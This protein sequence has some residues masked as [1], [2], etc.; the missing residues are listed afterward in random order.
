MQK[1][2]EWKAKYFSAEGKARVAERRS[3]LSPEFQEKANRD[4]EELYADVEASIG[5]D[6][7]GPKGQALAAR[8]KKLVDGFTGGDPEILKSL[9]AMM[10]DKANWPSEAQKGRFAKPQLQEFIRKA[11][12][13]KN[14]QEHNRGRRRNCPRGGIPTR[15]I[16]F[17]DQIS[18][19]VHRS[20][21][22]TTPSTPFASSVTTMEVI[23]RFSIRFNA[24]L[25]SRCGPIVCGPLVM[26][27]P[28]V[29]SRVAPRCFSI[30]RRRSPSV[31]I[32]A[33]LPSG[34]STVVIPRPFLLISWKTSGISVAVE[35]RGSASA[36]CI[37]CSTRSSF[38][39][40]RPAGCNAAKSS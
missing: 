24:S 2:A 23:F 28:A 14:R 36:A 13:G 11:L 38:L 1:T 7:Y 8:W 10:E 29:I 19:R 33:S 15:A 12:K 35:T 9:Q 37:R 31:R 22:C 39:P 27:C 34:S 20:C 25:A 21:R 16:S 18:S 3:Q 5:E 32:P 6:P 4:W 17:V 40:K 30:S 26:H